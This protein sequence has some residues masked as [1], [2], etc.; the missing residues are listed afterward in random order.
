ME[1]RHIPV[2]LESLKQSGR[3]GE[4]LYTADSLKAPIATESQG[5]RVSLVNMLHR[6][7]QWQGGGRILFSHAVSLVTI[8]RFLISSIE[9][10]KPM[11]GSAIKRRV[12]LMLFL[13]HE[14]ERSQARTSWNALWAHWLLELMYR[15][16]LVG[17]GATTIESCR[18]MFTIPD[19]FSPLP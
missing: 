12:V 18:S 3:Y 15:R 5:H 11:A 9:P 4:T 19:S 6:Y 17:A 1:S 7:W 8:T 14:S 10:A 2:R 13:P 16:P